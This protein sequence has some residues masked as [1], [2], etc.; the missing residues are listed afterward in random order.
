MTIKERYTIDLLNKAEVFGL[1]VSG[2]GVTVKKKPF[3]DAI[4]NS[5]HHTVAFHDILISLGI[6]RERTQIIPGLSEIL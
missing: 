2:D 1:S 4:A 3:L 6:W 5:T